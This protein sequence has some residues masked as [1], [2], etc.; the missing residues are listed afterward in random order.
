MAFIWAVDYYKH[1]ILFSGLY[2][3]ETYLAYENCF[4]FLRK[5]GFQ[6]KAIICD[7]HVAIEKYSE[8]T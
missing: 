3:S 4:R 1:D 2:P 6:A 5:I 8:G 7:E